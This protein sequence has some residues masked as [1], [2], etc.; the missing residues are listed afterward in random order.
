MGKVG[1]GGLCQKSAV[2]HLA[3]CIISADNLHRVLITCNGVK[4]KSLGKGTSTAC[5][6]VTGGKVARWQGVKVGRWQGPPWQGRRWQTANAR[7]TI[8][9][10]ICLP[11]GQS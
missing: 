2:S 5:H 10:L 6:L 3:S 7:L 1:E 4:L 11:V 8:R 9:R